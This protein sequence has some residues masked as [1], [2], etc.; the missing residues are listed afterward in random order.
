MD[1][2][3]ESVDKNNLYQQLCYL[4]YIIDSRGSDKLPGIISK[5]NFRVDDL[6]QIISLLVKSYNLRRNKG[7]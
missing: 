3:P 4:S 6:K 7:E 1:Y 2:S 5:D